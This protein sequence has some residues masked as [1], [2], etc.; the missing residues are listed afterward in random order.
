MV[1]S[2]QTI[3]IPGKI[4][5]G[6]GSLAE[7]GKE[8]AV[9]GKKAIIV[10]DQNIGK[11]GILDKVISDLN[12]HGVKTVVYDKIEP[13]PRCTTIDG[14]V[15]LARKENVDL[16]IGLGGGS[17]M[18]A[19][20]VLAAVSVTG[21]PTWDYIL[22]KIQVSKETLPII[23]VPTMAGTGSELNGGALVSNWELHEKFPIIHSFL[24]AKEAIIDPEI[25]LSVPIKQIRAGG[26]DIFTHVVEPYV[27]NMN[28]NQITD[29][30]RETTIR[31]VVENLPL[32]LKNPK[33][34]AVR[35]KLSWASTLAMSNLM[36][37]GGGGGVFSL[38][39]IEHAVS[40]YFDVTHAEG[41][42]ALMP[43]WMKFN[44]PAC[45]ERIEALGKNVFGKADGIAATEEWLEKVGLHVKLR[46][47]GV[48]LDKA[49][50]VGIETVKGGFG[51]TDNPIPL[52]ADL[53]A[54]IYRDAY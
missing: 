25:T 54:K 36:S 2:V 34:I 23:Q 13:N 18:D 17:V 6:V 46:D 4:L 16:V 44:Y 19:A 26:V 3:N 12:N 20:K 29:G 7:L 15:V 41:L 1:M 21:A 53:V 27:T 47:L 48:T 30:L 33:D 39:A 9:F 42:A 5:F 22:G 8:A 52:N 10:T 35:T 32:A 11:I 40:G 14:G 43:T 38:H 49:Q 51:M 45:K 50:E 28:S 37:L 31:A 24:F